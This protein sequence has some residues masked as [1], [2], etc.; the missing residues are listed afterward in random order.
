MKRLW[1]ARRLIKSVLPY[2]RIKP[3]APTTFFGK[4][5]I[6]TQRIIKV[7]WLKGENATTEKWLHT[8]IWFVE[9]EAVSPF[10]LFLVSEVKLSWVP[11]LWNVMML[12]MPFW[13][14][15]LTVLFTGS[16]WGNQS[17]GIAVICREVIRTRTSIPTLG[18]TWQMRS[19]CSWW[20]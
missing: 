6:W 15:P 20:I 1:Q 17:R 2:I 13:E 19:W 14:I 16:E 12:K 11:G 4:V 9:C 8:W 5:W 3:I 7:V 18:T 10:D